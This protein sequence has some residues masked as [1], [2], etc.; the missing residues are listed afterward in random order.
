MSA[1]LIAANKIR[2]DIGGLTGSGVAPATAVPASPTEIV[3]S[4]IHGESGSLSYLFSEFVPV[5][6]TDSRNPTA[7]TG[8]HGGAGHRDSLL[9]PLR[10][11]GSTISAAFRPV[12]Y[13]VTGPRTPPAEPQ[14]APVLAGATFHPSEGSPV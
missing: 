3:H 7:N 11:L 5:P 14:V 13:P 8:P 4:L 9:G 1:L 12:S 2:A 6:V 10:P